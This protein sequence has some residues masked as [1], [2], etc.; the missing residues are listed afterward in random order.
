MIRKCLL[1]AM[2]ALTLTSCVIT[3]EPTGPTQYDSRA[4][5]RDD[6]KEVNVHLTMGAGQ[7][8]VG[9]GTRK[10]MQGY[11]TYNVPSWKP[12]MRYSSGELTVE[13]PRTHSAHLG[14]Q[15]YEWDLR[16]AQDVPLNFH[17]NFGA[18]EATLDLGSLKLKN[19]DVEMGVGSIK[20]D[21][22]GTPKEDY[23]VTINGGVGEAVVR[24]PSDVGI[25]AEASGG[26]GEINARGLLK[27]DGHWITEAYNQPG[28]K[29]HVNVHGGIGSITL[30]AD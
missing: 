29:I 12:D 14:S 18:G 17:I 20:L 16:F 22:R 5:E 8:K 23:N 26:I 15:K 28:P 30:T 25:Y 13:Q 1:L 21:L 24:L 6:A 11:F 10:L 19:V 9:S 27:R 4:F 7:L 3:H 2:G